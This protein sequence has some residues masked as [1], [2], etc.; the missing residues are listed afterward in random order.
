MI[1]YTTMPQELIFQTAST[2]YAKQ[3][4]VYY[5]G[6][7][8]LVRETETKEYEIV[9]NLSTNPQHFLQAKYSPGMTILARAITS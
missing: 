7:P 1:L 3:Q 8:L 9:R 5:D 4:L 2:E 6:I